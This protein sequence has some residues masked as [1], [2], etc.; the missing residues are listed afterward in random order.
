MSKSFTANLYTEPRPTWKNRSQEIAHND[1]GF[2]LSKGKYRTKIRPEELPE[3]YVYGRYYK[4]WGYLSAKGVTSLYYRP[5]YV[6]N[7]M[8]K[9]DFL[10]ISYDKPI[11][12]VPRHQSIFGC[13]GF[14]E[15]ISGWNI[16]SFLKAAERHSNYDISE[17]KAE[18][19]KKRQWFETAYPEFYKL[20][21][22]SPDIF[23]G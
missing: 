8:F 22:P 14:D 20:E 15:Y 9:D 13:E 16:V 3:W 17:I 4:H 12:P 1:D 23:C 11:E 18:I 10:Y 2:L 7:H 6:F 19:E 5:N 21:V